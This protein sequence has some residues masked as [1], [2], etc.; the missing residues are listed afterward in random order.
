MPEKIDRVLPVK[1][2]AILELSYS[3]NTALE[4]GYVKACIHP[5]KTTLRLSSNHSAVKDTG[6]VSTVQKERCET[7]GKHPGRKALR[8]NRFLSFPFAGSNTGRLQE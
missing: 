8:I 3:F 2:H 4:F 6:V 7:Q 1:M 5:P